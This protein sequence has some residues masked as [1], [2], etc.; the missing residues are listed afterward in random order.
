MFF[1]PSVCY[2][3]MWFYYWVVISGKSFNNKKTGELPGI[4]IQNVEQND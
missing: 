4:R 3:S 1:F 2:V